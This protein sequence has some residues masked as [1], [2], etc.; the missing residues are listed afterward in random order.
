MQLNIKNDNN[1][2]FTRLQVYT[3]PFIVGMFYINDFFLSIK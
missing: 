1:T 3:W 2:V